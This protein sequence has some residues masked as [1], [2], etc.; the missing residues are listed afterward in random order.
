M[1]F[2]LGDTDLCFTVLYF[3]MSCIYALYVPSLNIMCKIVT[4]STFFW[5]LDT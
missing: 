3:S 1:A 5:L 4:M 2:V